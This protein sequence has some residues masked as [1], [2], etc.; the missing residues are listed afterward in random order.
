MTHRQRVLTALH[1]R[2]PAQRNAPSHCS[3]TISPH[4]INPTGGIAQS[5]EQRP[6][7]PWVLGSSPSPAIAPPEE[8]VRSVSVSPFLSRSCEM[9]RDWARPWPSFRGVVV[10]RGWALSSGQYDGQS[11]PAS[12]PG[13]GGVPSV[14]GAPA[15]AEVSVVPVACFASSSTGSKSG[16]L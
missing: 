10:G 5:V 11:A 16:R 9:P 15:I 8:D 13:S 1:H 4:K 6:F 12:A 3:P 14:A 2:M 7:K